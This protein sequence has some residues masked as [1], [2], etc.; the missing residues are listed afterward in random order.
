MVVLVVLA[1]INLGLVYRLYQELK[2]SE[3]RFMEEITGIES[4]LINHD[5]AIREKIK[6]IPK[7]IAIKNYLKIP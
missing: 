4:Y 6:K 3:Q 5:A 2:T 7:E 1:L